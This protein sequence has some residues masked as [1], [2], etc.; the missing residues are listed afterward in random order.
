MEPLIPLFWTS[1]DIWAGFQS[2]GGS[3]LHAFSLVWSSDSPLVRPADCIEVSMAAKPFW[4]TY[5]QTCP[6]KLVTFQSLECVLFFCFCLIHVCVCVCT[7]MKLTQ[8]VVGLKKV[9]MAIKSTS[10]QM[11]NF[12][13]QAIKCWFG[14]KQKM[15]TANKDRGSWC[16]ARKSE[17]PLL[18][19][20]NNLRDVHTG[21]SACLCWG[22]AIQV[23]KSSLNGWYAWICSQKKWM[24]VPWIA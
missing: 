21:I 6:W 4:S 12:A 19:I 1:G 13:F 22:R 20:Q 8:F 3:L 2:Q 15:E 5:L 17:K 11:P 14:E 23:V 16:C 10:L 9:V 24:V 18:V 7:W